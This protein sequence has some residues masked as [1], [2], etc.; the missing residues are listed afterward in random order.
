MR[1]N[2]SLRI[3]T[4]Q[5]EVS[6]PKAKASDTL[7][8]SKENAKD[9]S[10]SSPQSPRKKPSKVK[11]SVTFSEEP[12]RKEQLKVRQ[13]RRVN[14]VVARRGREYPFFPFTPHIYTS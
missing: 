11:K 1:T 12:T 14:D 5:K 2:T 4:R 3:D 13:Y 7:Q 6:S 8:A 10:S 9:S